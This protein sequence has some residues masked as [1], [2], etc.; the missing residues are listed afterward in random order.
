MEITTLDELLAKSCAATYAAHAL[1]ANERAALLH[2]LP[3]WK[4]AKNDQ[5]IQRDLT[6]KSFAEALAFTNA[7]GDLAEREHHHPNLHLTNYKQLMIELQTHDV[8][9]LS[10][11]DF[12][13][14]AKIEQL[15][16]VSP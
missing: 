5:W 7:I 6:L 1:S 9:D 12:I 13:L 16:T 15:V 2:L 4:F 3:A 11:N 14:A 8:A 10:L